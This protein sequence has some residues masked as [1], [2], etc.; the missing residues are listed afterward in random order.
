MSIVIFVVLYVSLKLP[1]RLFQDKSSLSLGW[2]A[3]T[4]GIDKPG[5]QSAFLPVFL[6]FPLYS[7]LSLPLHSFLL[8]PS[9]L[10]QA[11]FQIHFKD[12]SSVG[13]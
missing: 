5:L 3:L 10:C 4:A 8:P 2:S 12:T 7:G 9:L 13:I 11:V 1:L 6:P